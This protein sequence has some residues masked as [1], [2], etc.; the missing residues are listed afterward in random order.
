MLYQRG[1]LEYASEIAKYTTTIVWTLNGA[2]LLTLA[3]MLLART[4]AAK[5]I[6]I[7]SII[8]TIFAA[9]AEA[10][11][12]LFSRAEWQAPMNIVYILETAEGVMFYCSMLAAMLVFLPSVLRSLRQKP[13]RPPQQQYYYGMPGGH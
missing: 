3:V 11:F 7:T 4:R 5:G 2:A 1:S 8:F 10:L 12:A 13:A 9:S 6:A